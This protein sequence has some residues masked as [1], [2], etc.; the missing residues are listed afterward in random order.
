MH[1]DTTPASVQQ[2]GSLSQIS[3]GLPHAD[4]GWQRMTPSVPVPHAPEQQS[5]P[6]A[7]SSHSARHPPEAAQRFVPSPVVRQTREQ[8]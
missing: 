3:P 2:S 1:F 6:T 8:H 7:Q 4:A 5:D